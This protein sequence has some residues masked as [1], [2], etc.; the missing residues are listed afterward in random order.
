MGTDSKNT[1]FKGSLGTN[2]MTSWRAEETVAD[3]DERACRNGEDVSY[4][5]K[6]REGCWV[7]G[8]LHGGLCPGRAG[9]DFVASIRFS[10]A[11]LVEGRVVYPDRFHFRF[12]GDLPTMARVLHEHGLRDAERSLL[13]DPRFEAWRY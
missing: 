8:W 3:D 4:R 11:T 7:E 9:A 2:P 12:S 5:L 6:G 13:A 1:I 10:D